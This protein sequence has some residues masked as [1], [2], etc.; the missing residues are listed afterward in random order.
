MAVVKFAMLARD[1]SEP[2]VEVPMPR[3]L[4]L[5]M[6]SAGTEL[7]AYKSDEVAI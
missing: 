5:A 7:V 2:G 4:V 1:R 6:E 3:K